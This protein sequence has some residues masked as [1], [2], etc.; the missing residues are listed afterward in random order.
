MERRAQFYDPD[1]KL[2]Y[3]AD[4]CGPVKSAADKGELEL[5]TLARDAYP[6]KRLGKSELTGIK[7]IG[8]WNIKKQQDWG[9]DWHTNEGIEICYL[10]SGDLTFY[11]G[12]EKYDLA[13]NHLKIGRA[14]V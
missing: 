4:N 8:Y 12:D 7:S 6:G 11:L 10:E 13:T 9:L 3:K 1:G 14:H 2:S 5:T